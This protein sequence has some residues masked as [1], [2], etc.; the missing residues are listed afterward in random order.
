MEP[1]VHILIITHALSE[2]QEPEQI[3]VFNTYELAKDYYD[4][5]KEKR[6]LYCIGQIIKKKVH[7]KRLKIK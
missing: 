7:T 6:G 5:L 4:R 1:E 2:S 3:L